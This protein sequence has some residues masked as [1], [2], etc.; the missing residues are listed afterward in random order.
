MITISCPVCQKEQNISY[1]VEFDDINF[2]FEC[3]HEDSTIYIIFREASIDLFFQVDIEYNW[4][5][6]E[7][8]Q[9][10]YVNYKN[11]NYF[12]YPDFSNMP[13]LLKSLNMI[14][15]FQ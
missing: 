9:Y 8:L 6:L 7:D 10:M 5:F 2:S 11:C 14:K 4:F 3:N 13:K 15:T 1:Y 12:I